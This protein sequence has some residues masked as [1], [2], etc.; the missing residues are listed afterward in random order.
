MEWLCCCLWRRQSGCNSDA[1]VGVRLVE[2]VVAEVVEKVEVGTR[3]CDVVGVLRGGSCSRRRGSCSC[4]RSGCCSC[5]RGSAGV[6]MSW[7]KYVLVLAEVLDE[8][9]RSMC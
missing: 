2:E 3:V 1:V 7:L 5:G 4:R 6:V 8:V 9:V